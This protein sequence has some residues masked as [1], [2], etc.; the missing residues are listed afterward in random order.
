MSEIV[1]SHGYGASADSVWF[2][3]LTERLAAVGHRVTVPRLP[4]TEAPR[5]GPWRETFGD[6]AVAA[7]PAGSTVLVG[8]SIG[9]VNVLRFLE[10]HDPE[11]NGVFAGVLL[12]AT[13]AH[14]VGYDELAPFFE[15]GFDWERIRR[16]ARH[17]R[18]LQAMDDPVNQPDPA[19]HV[20]LLVEGLGATAVVTPT[21]AHFGATPDDHVEVP[22]AVRLVTELLTI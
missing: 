6:A 10:Q 2:P 12:V 7:G 8:H 11:A 21:G 19:E 14:E 3:Y 13:S 22:E 16:S 9:G 5:L 4:H 15:G 20:R 1:V 18:V 17:F